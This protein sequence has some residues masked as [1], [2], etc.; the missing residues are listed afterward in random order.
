M[1]QL[2][3]I[4]LGISRSCEGEIRGC[5]EH[6]RRKYDRRNSIERAIYI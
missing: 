4:S 6:G 1:G 3:Q 5:E 2:V